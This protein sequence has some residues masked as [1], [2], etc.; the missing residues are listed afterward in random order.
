MEKMKNVHEQYMKRCLELAERGRGFVH[1]NPLVGCVLV[2]DG[3]IVGEGYH[4]KY[5]GPHAEVYA[6]KAAGAQAKQ[7][8]AYVTL[9]P[10]SHY[11]KTPPCVHALI[12]AGVK[13]VVIA[14][15]D[16]NPLVNGKGIRMLKKAGITVTTGV[17]EA[18]ARKLNEK[19]FYAMEQNKPYVAAKCAQT[20]DGKMVDA[21]G[22][23]Q[24]ITSEEARK[25]AHRLRSLFD[26]V[27]VGA[28]TILEDNSELTVRAL[29]GRN[30]VRVVVDGKLRV[31]SDA[32]IFSTETARTIVLT[33]TVALEQKRKKVLTLEQR[34]AEVFGI[35]SESHIPVES[36]LRFLRSYGFTSVLVEG[37]G[38]T[39][40]HFFEAKSVQYMY[41]FIAPLLLGGGK[42]ITFTRPK[43]LAHAVRIEFQKQ[44]RVGKD[45]L[46][47]GPVLPL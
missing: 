43:S 18:E 26:C 39:L 29:K 32:K 28:R 7:A 25:E 45:V 27:L 10:C 37:G 38:A 4:K 24:W 35:G 47:E 34:G 17:M 14:T 46:L 36:I 15:K 2:K 44:R 9:E 12:A 1:P 22:R 19:F 13:H 6:L 5:G 3:K 8:T 42:G 30:P 21:Y 23:S 33:S 20:L 41:C 16:P 11:G 31:P 40:A